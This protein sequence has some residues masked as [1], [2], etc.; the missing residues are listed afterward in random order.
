MGQ[1]IQNNQTKQKALSVSES[2]CKKMKVERLKS[3]SG[4]VSVQSS[5]LWPSLYFTIQCYNKRKA[6]C[7]NIKHC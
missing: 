5:Y 7:F 3:V 2:I 6:K 4:L 1:N